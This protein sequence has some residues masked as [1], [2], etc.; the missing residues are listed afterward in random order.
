[1]TKNPFK[2]RMPLVAAASAGLLLAAAVAL[3]RLGSPCGNEILQESLSPGSALKAV[4]FRR[5][6]GAMK[7]LSLHV[8]VVPAAASVKPNAGGNVFV[9]DRVA[10]H[11]LS[12]EWL[13]EQRLRVSYPMSA[14]LF[15]AEPG[16]RGL[17]VI[18]E[19]RND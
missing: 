12:A 8:A 9:A 15:S 16:V 3:W 2:V 10:P 4:V 1:L 14:R 13:S 5:N 11:A 18:Y 19:A 7:D 17:R 6:C